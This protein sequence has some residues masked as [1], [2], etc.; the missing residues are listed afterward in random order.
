TMLGMA[1]PALV[2]ALPLL[3]VGLSVVRRFLRNEPIFA[4]GRGHIHHRLLDRGVS[5]GPV[6]ISLYVGCG[7]GASISLIESVLRFRYAAGALVVFGIAFCLG[8]RYLD[9]AEF[10]A[11]WNLWAGLRPML[12]EHVELQLLESALKSAP[13]VDQCWTV[14]ERTAHAL[15]Y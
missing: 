13:S 1:A 11:T 14:L 8:V 2:M 6:A 10:R 15:G 5:P 4:G 3:E 7:L 9:Y 12:G